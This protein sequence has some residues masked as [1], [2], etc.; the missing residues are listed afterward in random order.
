M[1]FISKM[2]NAIKNL[3]NKDVFFIISLT[4][5]GSFF[6]LSVLYGPQIFT[7]L[8]MENNSDWTTLDHFYPI[9]S[10]QIL[11]KAYT[12]IGAQYPPISHI[13]FA[14]F[15]KMLNIRGKEISF[16]MAYEISRFPYALMLYVPYSCFCFLLYVYAISELKI[17]KKYKVM[18][19]FSFLFSTPIFAGALERGNMVLLAGGILSIGLVWRTSDSK[20]KQEGALILIALSAAI[21]IYPA[22]FGILYLKKD[23][24]WQAIRLIIYGVLLLLGPFVFFDKGSFIAFIHNNMNV[25]EYDSVGRVQCF[26]GLLQ[27]FGVSY[28]ASRIGTLILAVLLLI[29]AFMSQSMIRKNVYLISIMM[30]LPTNQYRY[31]LL[32]FIIPLFILFEDTESHVYKSEKWI[33]TIMLSM[34]FS[35][36]TL[37]GLITH[38]EL[39]FNMRT[40]T[41]VEAFIYAI[42]WGTLLIQFIYDIYD[43]IK[44]I[45]QKKQTT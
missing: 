19:V 27:T 43:A 6:A 28:N 37:F 12:E 39:N 18:L 7:W 36:P 26:Q 40:F 21:K 25:M 2:R 41:Y 20:Y 35:I 8:N 33:D 38:F 32:F 23:T 15:S 30:F 14:F 34:L 16:I 11:H 24:I 4:G 45:N 22:V 3:N 5:I 31:M 10:S 9:L 44:A 13:I 1:N 42:G 29:G 17:D